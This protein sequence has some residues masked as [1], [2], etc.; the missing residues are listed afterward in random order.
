MN[1]DYFERGATSMIL[2]PQHK[3]LLTY[4]LLGDPELEIYKSTR[5]GV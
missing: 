5:E 1:S 3:N 2:E 4:N